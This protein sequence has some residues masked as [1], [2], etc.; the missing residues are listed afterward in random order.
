MDDWYAKLDRKRCCGLTTVPL[1]SQQ[2]L[3]QL[4][5]SYCLFSLCCLTAIHSRSANGTERLVGF[6]RICVL[7]V[8]SRDSR[9][10]ADR[11]GSVRVTFLLQRQL[12]FALSVLRCLNASRP[13]PLT[14]QSSLSN[15][16]DDL[17]PTWAI[18]S[19]VYIFRI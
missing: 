17:C 5:I 2:S 11:P 4:I 1:A 16:P 13:T 7:K 15:H 8:T 3:A 10:R 9:A 19:A 18:V 6:R 12:L 14:H